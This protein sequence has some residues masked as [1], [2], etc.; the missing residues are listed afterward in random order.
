MIDGSHPGNVDSRAAL[1]AALEGVPERE[2]GARFYCVLVYVRDAHD[3]RPLRADGL[4]EGRIL[5]SER[6]SGG[7]GYDPVFYLPE[8]GLTMAQ[9]SPEEKNAISHRGRAFRMMVEACFG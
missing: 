8:R 6:G 1:Q 2:R 3:P 9:L 7:F 5:T 4:W